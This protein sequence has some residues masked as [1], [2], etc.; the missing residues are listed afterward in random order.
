MEP[1]REEVSRLAESLGWSVERAFDLLQSA[2]NQ[3]PDD[4]QENPQVC[5]SGGRVFLSSHSLAFPLED[6][7]EKDSDRLSFLSQFEIRKKS[8]PRLEFVESPFDP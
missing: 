6:V 4:R 3:D 1:P 8:T 2:A 5:L 7:L